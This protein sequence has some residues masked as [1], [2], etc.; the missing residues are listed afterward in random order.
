MWIVDVPGGISMR[1]RLANGAASLAGALVALA[2]G[3]Q[4]GPPPASTPPAATPFRGE[5]SVAYVLVPVVAESKTGFA[6][7]LSK[8]DFQLTV[9][10]R[11]VGIESFESG[12]DAPVG[13][14]FL[15]DLSGSMGIGAKLDHSRTLIRCVLGLERA[16]DEFAVAS[17]GDRKLFVEVPF[18]G[19]REAILEAA[20]RFAGYGRTALHDAVGWLPDL[21]YSRAT[22]R[23]AVVLLTDGVDN[24]SVLAPAA[25]RNEVRQAEVPVHVVG[26]ETGSIDAVDAA[27]DKVHRLADTL[28]LI[29]WATGGSYRSTASAADMRRACREIVEQL[30][31]QYVLGF[32]TRAD[33]GAA[34]HEIEVE[35]PGKSKKLRLRFRRSYHGAE[36]L[37]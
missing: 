29:G 21:V 35:V 9:D 17:F 5:V 16:G 33:G 6:A 8:N 19:T 31:H 7:G 22:P 2:A 13:I 15:Q 34:L 25:A 10:G 1:S 18:P 20:A 36:P 27:G 26:L 32:S 12:A 11:P 14:L 24:A 23:R 4:G 28:N 3:A 30:R 37:E